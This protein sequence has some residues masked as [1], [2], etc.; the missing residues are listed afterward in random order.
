[1]GLGEGPVILQLWCFM[2]FTGVY[3]NYFSNLNLC[4]VPSSFGSVMTQMWLVL[5]KEVRFRTCYS[6]AR[7][8]ADLHNT[9]ASQNNKIV[10]KFQAQAL[11]PSIT[12]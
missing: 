3:T 12:R 11:T 4:T 7:V 5:E 2:G 6:F 10:Y 9:F 1:M 8:V